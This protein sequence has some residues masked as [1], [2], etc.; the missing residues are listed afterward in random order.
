MRPATDSP[1]RISK[2]DRAALVFRPNA[3]R[4]TKNLGETQNGRRTHTRHRNRTSRLPHR[5]AQRQTTNPAIGILS[6]RK[7]NRNCGKCEGCRKNRQNLLAAGP[8]GTTKRQPRLLVCSVR[9]SFVKGEGGDHVY[10]VLSTAGCLARLAWRQAKT[11]ESRGQSVCGSP[12]CGGGTEKPGQ[13]QL[14]QRSAR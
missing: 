11:R 14:W 5:T 7:R 8:S 10:V 9:R 2:L 13:S 12:R 4:G 1:A 3:R 6:S